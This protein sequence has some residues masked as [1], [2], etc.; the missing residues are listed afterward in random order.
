MKTAYFDCIFGVS[1]DMILGALTACGVPVNYLKTELEKLGVKGFDLKEETVNYGGISAIQI[2]VTTEHQQEHRHLSQIQDIIASSAVSERVKE[3]AI[4]IFERLADAEAKV[5]GTTPE[6][7]HFHEVGALDAIVDVVGACIGFEYLGIEKMVSTPLRLGTGTV[8]CA[9]GV[10]PVPVPAVCELTRK[11]PVVRTLIE[12]EI[13]TPT[14]AAI[15][16]TLSSSYDTVEHFTA[17]AVG[18]GAGT[19]EREDFPN[20]LRITIGDVPGMFDTDQCLLLETNIDDMNPEVYGYLSDRLFEAGAKDVFMSP[21][22]MKKGRPGTILSILTDDSLITTILDMLFSETTTTG[23]RITRVSRK[24]LKRESRR[25]KTEFGPVSVKV[26]SI[27]GNE[28][29]IPEFEEC[30]RI[31]RERGLP[32]ITV[33][34]RIKNSC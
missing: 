7:I 11:I 12:G 13:T 2:N 14:G 19:N 25:I 15:V 23:I 18:Y 28:R 8:K 1:G 17:G 10:M 9:H 22:Y 27:N 5:H 20:V 3:Q 24:K 16:T 6:K 21:V 30:A 33:Y 29:F 4:S 31:A 34:E 26:A 32:L